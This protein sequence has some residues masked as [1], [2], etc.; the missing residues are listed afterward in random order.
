VDRKTLSWLGLLGGFF[1]FLL[2]RVAMSPDARGDVA[3][4]LRSWLHPADVY[5]KRLQR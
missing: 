4:T 5:G 3:W 1:L 2:L